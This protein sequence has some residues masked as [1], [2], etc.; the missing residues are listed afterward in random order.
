LCEEAFDLFD[1]DGDGT[2]DTNELKHLLRC[3]ERDFDEDTIKKLV[4]KYDST[5]TGNLSF[6]DI[7]EILKPEFKQTDEIDIE[8]TQAFKVFD[9]NDKGVTATELSEVMNALL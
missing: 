5:G 4:A 9:R 1:K 2:M 3:F 8:V 7:V 6:P